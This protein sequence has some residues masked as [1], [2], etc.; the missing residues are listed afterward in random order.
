MKDLPFS[1]AAGQRKE[2]GTG[3]SGQPLVSVVTA[4]YNM[5]Q[6]LAEAVLSVLNQDY[7]AVE[8]IVIDDGSTDDTAAVLAP[9]ADDQRVTVI[10]QPNAGQ[11]VAKN[12]GMR[13]A[14][15]K[16]IGFCDADNAWLPDKLSRQVHHLEKNPRLGV[17]Y[18]DIQFM[19]ENGAPLPTP[20]V[21]RHSGRITGKLLADNFVTFNTTLAPRRVLEEFEYMDES[22]T[23]AIDYDL[24]LRI[25]TRHDFLHL[26][27]TLVRY[28]I[29]GGQ[30]SHKTGERM[31]NFFRLLERF[32]ARYPG[33]VT[34]AEIRRAWAHSY[35]TRGRWHAR[36]RRHGK[37]WADYGRALS[38]RPHDLRLWK[39]LV[40]L[41]LRR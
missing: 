2:P 25:S 16:Y 7:P 26:P 31:D 4:T 41:L 23:M 24:W 13:Q 27:E 30:M 35:V 17:I 32:L 1:L 9:F 22:L 28:R 10:Q 38:Q 3:M 12:R 20:A 36:E 37:A 6:Y 8:L 14:R 34:P 21:R 18:G 11:T 39:S 40:K 19:D 29:W 33:S 5:S 15:G